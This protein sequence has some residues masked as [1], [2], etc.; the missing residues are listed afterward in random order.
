MTLCKDVDQKLRRKQGGLL[1]RFL[2]WLQHTL[3]GVT[4]GGG[5]NNGHCYVNQWINEEPDEVEAGVKSIG[6]LIPAQAL[7]GKGGWGIR[8]G[9]LLGKG[10]TG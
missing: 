6:A 9:G 7:W 3:E 5:E 1:F 2:S 4:V 10:K 8:G